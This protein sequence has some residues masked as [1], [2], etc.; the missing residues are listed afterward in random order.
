MTA[1]VG[2]G[3]YGARLESGARQLFLLYAIFVA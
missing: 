1:G 3:V 2:W